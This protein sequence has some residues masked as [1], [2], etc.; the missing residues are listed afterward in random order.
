MKSIISG[1]GFAGVCLVMLAAAGCGE[2][3]DKSAK[4]TSAPPGTG[5]NAPPR[6]QAEYGKRNQALQGSNLKSQG[7]PGA[8]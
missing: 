8:K 2:D 1:L 5:A 7:Y 3:N 6:N 4:L